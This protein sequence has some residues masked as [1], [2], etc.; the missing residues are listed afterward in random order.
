MVPEYLVYH[1]A[2]TGNFTVFLLYSRLSKRHCYFLVKTYGLLFQNCLSRNSRPWVLAV[3]SWSSDLVFLRPCSQTLLQES[4]STG[5]IGLLLPP[6]E[7]MH[8]EPLAPHLA[9]S[10]LTKVF[11]DVLMK[12]FYDGCLRCVRC[13]IC[14]III[15]ICVLFFLA[16]S[17]FVCCSRTSLFIS[18]QKFRSICLS[19]HQL[20]LFVGERRFP[21]TCLGLIVYVLG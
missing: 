7:T 6:K 16:L 12:F 3:P 11:Y 17:C 9:P 19:S 18:G 8:K 20:K 10:V 2:R 4:N 15:I 5:L 13:Y 1:L 21:T 14:I